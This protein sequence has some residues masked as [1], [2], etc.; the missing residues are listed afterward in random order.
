M[1]TQLESNKYII[2]ENV[3]SERILKI[4]SSYT[5]L[6]PTDK[7]TEQYWTDMHKLY[8][9]TP[10]AFTCDVLGK[11]RMEIISELF[12]NTRLPCYHKR[13]LRDADI[14][15][16]KMPDGTFVP[17][18]K[19]HCIFSMTLFI[20]P[21]IDYTGGNFLWWDDNN[22]MLTVE[23]KY[24]TGIV[25]YY[26]NFKHGANHQ[27]TTIHGGIRYTM[28]LFVFDKRNKS[29]DKDKYALWEKNND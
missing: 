21:T 4:L 25:A 22:N 18:H 14:A 24:N 16:H 12:E 29:T 15:I 11:D 26:D 19:D 17:K 10:N 23:P 28:Q 2:F 27:V 5:Q 20:S 6:L 13:W 7:R 8:P 3:F 1:E 9:D